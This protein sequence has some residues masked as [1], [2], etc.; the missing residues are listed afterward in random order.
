MRKKKKEFKE[1]KKEGL[2]W[3]ENVL[4]KSAESEKSVDL[5]S[6]AARLR[7]YAFVPHTYIGP[8]HIVGRYHGY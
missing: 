8:R 1:I 3:A 5:E 6:R 4:L 7:T 2:G